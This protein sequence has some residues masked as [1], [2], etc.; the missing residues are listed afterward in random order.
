MVVCQPIPVMSPDTRREDAWHQTWVGLS[1]ADQTEVK[2]AVDRGRA[3]SRSDLAPVAA[4]F[5]RRR[6]GSTSAPPN[7]VRRVLQVLAGATSLL[8]GAFFLARGVSD[9]R[10]VALI[11]GALGLLAGVIWLVAVPRRSRSATTALQANR[12]LSQ[13]EG[14]GESP[15]V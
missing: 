9:H 10:P 1:R 11:A 4:E 13:D 8:F 5:A 12:D 14:L 6:L 7:R 2:R 15:P 3:V